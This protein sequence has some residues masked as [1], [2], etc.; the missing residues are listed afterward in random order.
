[1][2][3]ACL[4]QLEIIGEAA[5][6]LSDELHNDTDNIEWGRIIVLRNLIAHEYFGISLPIIW[7]III[8]KLPAIKQK[9]VA[10]LSTQ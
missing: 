10:L 9:V 5:N 4:K 3:N 2:N 6:H 8:E 7:K 1:M